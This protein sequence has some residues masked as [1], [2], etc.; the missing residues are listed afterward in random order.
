L[1]R[2][3]Q[4]SHALSQYQSLIPHTRQYLED[5]PEYEKW[6]ASR[7]QPQAPAPQQEAAPKQ[8]ES[9]WN[10]P[11]LRDAYK[12]YIVR[13]EN[14]RET[15]HPDTPLDAKHAIA[16]YFDYRKNFAEKFLSNPEEALS[17]MVARLAQQQAET[18]IQSRLEDLGRQQYVATLEEKNREWLFDKNGNVSPEGEAA[19][20]YIEQ[21]KGLG[22]ASP[23]A[24]WNYALQM[25]ER[26]LLH[27]AR[28][29]QSREAQQQAFQSQLG[30]Y[31][32]PPQAPPAPV[33]TR[34]SQ[35]E[36]N[37]DYLR[38]AASRTANRAG[39]TTN[40]PEVG[41]RGT[42]FEERLRQQ[43]EGEGLI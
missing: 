39:V 5:K 23:E 16:E 15:M 14:G 24:R 9:W 40:S 10:P 18:L 1:E 13:D 17:P 43:L 31:S 42:G 19:R 30:A 20:N 25:V 41:R 37:M 11:Q 12:R 4:A 28:S 32:P 38:R 27:Q 2:E 3:K 34:A 35:A 33:A 29:A 7:F 21:A 22:I 26:D 6:R 8:P 36:A